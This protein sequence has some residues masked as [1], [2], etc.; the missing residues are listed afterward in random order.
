MNIK[1]LNTMKKILLIAAFASFAFASQ[2]QNAKPAATTAKPQTQNAE[3][4]NAEPASVEVENAKPA[5]EEKK[6]CCSSKKSAA[7][8]CEKKEEKKCE[9]KK[10]CCSKK[11]VKT[12][13]VK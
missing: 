1:F 6:A 7:K 9:S 2:A 3:V 8:S 5:S 4:I 11:T 12:E 13:E 10:A